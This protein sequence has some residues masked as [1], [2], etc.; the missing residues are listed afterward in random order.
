[1]RNRAGEDETYYEACNC[2]KR[3]ER[4]GN[5]GRVRKER[6]CQMDG[7]NQK[8]ERGGRKKGGSE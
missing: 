3:A 7:G 1:M 8:I 2:G 6:G 5:F 4:K